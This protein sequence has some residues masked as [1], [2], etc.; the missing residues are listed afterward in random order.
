MGR[1]RGGTVCVTV[2][3]WAATEPIFHTVR[4]C[5]KTFEKEGESCLFTDLKE[6]CFL[7]T[8]KQMLRSAQLL[9]RERRDTASSSARKERDSGVSNL[10][11]TMRV[12]EWEEVR[13]GHEGK[14]STHCDS[15]WE[16]LRKT[17]G[18]WQVCL[19]RG[20]SWQRAAE[21]L[22]QEFKG[23]KE[24]LRGGRTRHWDCNIFKSFVRNRG[25][26]RELVI[27]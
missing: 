14:G 16:N 9:E 25:E 19:S 26:N 1:M 17:R 11:G 23:V 18:T 5:F 12:H 22:R 24:S 21:E 15:Y 2:S 4:L 10:L 6:F 7:K 13:A 8:S 20:R 3:W 27:V